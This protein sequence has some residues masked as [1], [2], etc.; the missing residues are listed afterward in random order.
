[1]HEG[2]KLITPYPADGGTCQ[3]RQLLAATNATIP[4]ICMPP[5]DLCCLGCGKRHAN[6]Y[7][8]TFDEAK[9]EDEPKDEPKDANPYIG[10]K[11]GGQYLHV[12]FCADKKQCF[13]RASSK[14]VEF[15]TAVTQIEHHVRQ[16]AT[17]ADV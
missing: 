10:R 11:D 2:S 15:L 5:D 7:Y 16:G 8:C 14:V 1:M 12:P 6:M 17:P 3:S 13:M 9:P 4:N